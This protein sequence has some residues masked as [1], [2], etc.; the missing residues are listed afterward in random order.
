MS[1]DGRVRRALEGDDSLLVSRSVALDDIYI[2]AGGTGR[3]VVAY[4]TVWMTPAEIVDSDGHYREQNAPDSMTKSIA[5]RAGRIFSIYNHGK[6]LSGTPSDVHSVPLGKPLEIR[7]DKKGLLTVTR[8]NKDPEADRILEAIKSGSLTGMSYTG[9]FLRSDPQLRPFERYAPD[10]SGELTLV[11]RQ[12]IAL[13]EYGPT[14]IPAYA[15]AAVIG[16]RSGRL[17]IDEFGEAQERDTITIQPPVPDEEPQE[18]AAASKPMGAADH[19]FEN[20]M[21][22]TCGY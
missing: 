13:I 15:E 14:P 11:T 3:D 16:V 20:G 9:V 21:C 17:Q 19:V 1:T 12:E 6:T 4:A 7:A 18:R 8:Y 10:R 5:D 2:R 22:V